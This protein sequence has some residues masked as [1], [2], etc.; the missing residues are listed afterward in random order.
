MVGT[1]IDFLK[2]RG[3]LLLCNYSCSIVFPMQFIHSVVFD[4]AIIPAQSCSLISSAPLYPA[5]FFL[6]ELSAK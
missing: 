4:C 5:E 6:A 1:F 3:F 2:V